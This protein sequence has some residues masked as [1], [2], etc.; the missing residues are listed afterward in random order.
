MEYRQLGRTGVQVSPLCLGTMNF[1]G[2]TA[3]KDALE[4]LMSMATL[5]GGNHKF[6]LLLEDLDKVKIYEDRTTAFDGF[7]LKLDKEEKSISK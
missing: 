1:G 6:Y 2:P 4:K 3:E 7:I 5:G